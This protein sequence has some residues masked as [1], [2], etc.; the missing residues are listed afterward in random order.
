MGFVATVSFGFLPAF[1]RILTKQV[2][3]P[4]YYSDSNISK[5]ILFYI[6]YFGGHNYGGLLTLQFYTNCKE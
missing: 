5:L 4:K 2:R 1:M 3:V 6:Y